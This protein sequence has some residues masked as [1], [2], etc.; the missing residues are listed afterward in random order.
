MR[1]RRY[2]CYV[3]SEYP[4]TPSSNL[5]LM[6]TIAYNIRAGQSH[7]G[8]LAM[9]VTTDLATKVTYV[10]V[11][12]CSDTDSDQFLT[13][14]AQAGPAFQ[15]PM[16]LPG[17]FAEIQRIK[18]VKIVRRNVERLYEY[19]IDLSN[20]T[21]PKGHDKEDSASDGVKLWRQVSHDKLVLETWATQL[22]KMVA[23][24]DE[25]NEM[26]YGTKSVRRK[27]VVMIREGTRI[28]ERLQ[29]IIADYDE[30]QRKCASVIEGTTLANG[31]VCSLKQNSGN[32]QP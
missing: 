1:V 5:I 25:L 16:L 3:R 9:S 29:D 6:G 11:Y 28:K 13:R 26:A 2:H 31:T 15:H 30:L 19:V 14:L 18:H 4:S 8:D 20:N 21:L 17:L 12:G 32:L 7:S 23:H 24:V 22:K 10:I 27:N